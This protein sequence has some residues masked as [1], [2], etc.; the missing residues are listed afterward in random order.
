MKNEE[1]IEREPTPPSPD[2][3]TKA[4]SERYRAEYEAAAAARR[5]L[6]A[7]NAP[8]WRRA[9]ALLPN[10][11]APLENWIAATKRRLNNRT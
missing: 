6:L 7:L 1:G 4:D 9:L 8:W 10:P 5:A 3:V 11:K 2:R